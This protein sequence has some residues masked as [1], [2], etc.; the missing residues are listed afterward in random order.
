MLVGLKGLVDA[1]HERERIER[2]IKKIEKDLAAL[3]EE[4]SSPS[5]TDKAP[6]EVVEEAH[7]QRKAIG[8]KARAG[9]TE[10]PH[11][12]RRALTW[13]SGTLPHSRP[14][15][16]HASGRTDAFGPAPSHFAK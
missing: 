6:K 10:A 14:D 2:E 9:L 7:A 1:A 13:T 8:G 5:F 3:D 4:A 15:L 12:R 11:A 16:P